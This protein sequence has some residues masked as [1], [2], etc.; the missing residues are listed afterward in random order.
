MQ[1]LR[2]A[3][4]CTPSR[5]SQSL[6]DLASES[7]CSRMSWRGLDSFLNTRNVLG[8]RNGAPRLSLVVP[9]PQKWTIPVPVP[10]KWTIPIP[11][12]QKWTIP[13][14]VPQKWTIPVPVPFLRRGDTDL[15]SFLKNSPVQFQ[16]NS[17]NIRGMSHDSKWHLSC[18]LSA[19]WLG[20]SPQYDSSWTRLVLQTQE[21]PWRTSRSR[22]SPYSFCSSFLNINTWIPWNTW[23]HPIPVVEAETLREYINIEQW[24]EDKFKERVKNI[25]RRFQ[26]RQRCIERGLAIKERC[27]RL[28]LCRCAACKWGL[29]DRHANLGTHIAWSSA[30]IA[31]LHVPNYF[32]EAT[33]APMEVR[34]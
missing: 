19:T 25:L 23:Q 5:R 22:C 4:W 7:Q 31:S 10:Q 16:L 33:G 17:P 11:V 3:C 14:P 21:R 28:P 1:S 8:S 24:I 30:M 18:L 27:H 26:W 20:I 15:L 12:P 2:L 13:V 9:V 34:K 6:W 32:A 29:V